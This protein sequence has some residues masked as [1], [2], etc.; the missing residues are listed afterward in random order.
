MFIFTAFPYGSDATI[1]TTVK[2]ISSVHP[3]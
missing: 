1:G 2:I 3:K